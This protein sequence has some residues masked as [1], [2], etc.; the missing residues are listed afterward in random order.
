M[1]VKRFDKPAFRLSPE[2]RKHK[3][4]YRAGMID[5]ILFAGVMFVAGIVSMMVV[6]SA[7]R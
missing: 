1:R 7:Y 4:E 2:C 3:K 5:F 6:F